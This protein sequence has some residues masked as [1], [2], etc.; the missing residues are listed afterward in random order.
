MADTKGLA[1]SSTRSLWKGAITF[2]LVHIPIGL[3][4]ATEETDVDFDWL[5]KRTMDPVGYKRI[6][7][8]TGREIEKENVVKGIAHGKGNYVV[9]SPEE[10]AEAFPRSTQTIEI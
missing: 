6:N 3:Y 10:I 9:L 7:K 4:S 8:R 2:G 1:N 5:D